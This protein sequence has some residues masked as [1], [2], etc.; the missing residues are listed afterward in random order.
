LSWNPLFEIRTQQAGR[1]QARVARWYFF[2][3]KNKYLGIFCRA[4]ELKML[5]LLMVI[6]NIGQP[7]GISYGNLVH[8]WSFGILSPVLECCTNKN[9]APLEQTAKKSEDKIM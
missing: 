6:W 3:T 2:K 4:L 9:L 7:F 8:F 5:V 1:E